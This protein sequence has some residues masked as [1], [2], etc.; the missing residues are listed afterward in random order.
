MRFPRVVL[1]VGVL[2]FFSSA[3]AEAQQGSVEFGIDAGVVASI[4][5]NVDNL[6]S[7]CVPCQRLRIGFFVSDAISFEPAVALNVVTGGGE[8]LTT[9][10]GTAS[11]LY[12]FTT[13]PDA[14]RAYFRVGGGVDVVDFG[15]GSLTQAGVGGGIGI[16]GPAGGIAIR[17][18]AIA[19]YN[20]ETDDLVSSIDLGVLL[21]IS[22][23]TD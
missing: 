8:T 14:S 1:T 4:N 10:S 21:G 11:L 13:D 7:I 23:F 9:F 16:K 20:F 5:D 22:F 18:E 6:T 2:A 3:A 19:G 12:H 15:G 17:A